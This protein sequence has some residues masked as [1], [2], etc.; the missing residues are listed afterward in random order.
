MMKSTSSL[1]DLLRQLADGEHDKVEAEDIMALPPTHHR[2]PF[3]GKEG[4]IKWLKETGR[5]FGPEEKK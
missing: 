3:G 5:W 2:Y 1:G 4:Y